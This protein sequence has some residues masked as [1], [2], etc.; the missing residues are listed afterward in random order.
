[1]RVQ[2]L[3]SSLAFI[4]ITLTLTETA[5]GQIPLDRIPALEEESSPET[6]P[7][8]P[9]PIPIPRNETS[10][11]PISDPYLLGP[12]DTI[13]VN[14]FEEEEFSGD[15]GR[16]RILADGSITLP[17]VGAIPVAGLTLEEASNVITEELSDLLKRP[18]V[19][20]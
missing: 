18:I 15:N 19:N 12:G 4:S 3:V 5:K 6:Q 11:P 8:Q 2:Y 9:Q 1:M 13:Q 17:L 20:V 7:N 10:Q 14:V 16:Q